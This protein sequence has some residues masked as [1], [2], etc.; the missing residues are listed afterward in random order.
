M[1]TLLLCEECEA[2]TA[3]FERGW[4]TYIADDPD[5]PSVEPLV[6]TYCPTCAVREFGP[7]PA[8]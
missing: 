7:L 5:E 2:A 4:R 8:A 3:E 1:H 6:A